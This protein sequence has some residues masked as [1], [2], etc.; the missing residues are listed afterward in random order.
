M[1]FWHNAEQMRWS[2]T[3]ERGEVVIRVSRNLNSSKLTNKKKIVTGK[4]LEKVET[5]NCNHKILNFA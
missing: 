1:G 3:K 2:K 4:I 5:K